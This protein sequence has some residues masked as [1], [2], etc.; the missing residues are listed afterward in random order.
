LSEY[1]AIVKEHIKCVHRK[2]F[3][4]ICSDISIY[5]VESVIEELITYLDTVIEDETGAR[6]CF[7]SNEFTK[8]QNLDELNKYF[9]SD[10]IL[11]VNALEEAG[12]LKFRSPLGTDNLAEDRTISEIKLA[13]KRVDSLLSSA[14]KLSD[15]EEFLMSA[16]RKIT[17]GRRGGSRKPISKLEEGDEAG[18]TGPAP[19]ADAPPPAN[20]PGSA[21]APKKVR[22]TFLVSTSLMTFLFGAEGGPQIKACRSVLLLLFPSPTA[23]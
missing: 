20:P 5:K 21:P 4:S 8:I 19:A 16:D 1:F 13:L 7:R 18:S 12:G 10:Y 11:D 3:E 6:E 22:T 14:F 17:K 9:R 23:C 2:Q 15:P